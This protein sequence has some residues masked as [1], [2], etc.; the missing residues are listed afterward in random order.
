[1]AEQIP[2]RGI[3]TRAPAIPKLAGGQCPRDNERNQRE[4]RQKKFCDV[5]ESA[6]LCFF[7][8]ARVETFQFKRA[9][10]FSFFSPI[11]SRRVVVLG[12]STEKVDK[13]CF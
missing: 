7:L 2:Q 10:G 6:E 5:I 8:C 3:R 9:H 4:A 12:Q 1:M 13:G 11:P